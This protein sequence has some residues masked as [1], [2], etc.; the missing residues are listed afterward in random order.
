M[1]LTQQAM[2]RAA[3][4]ESGPFTACLDTTLDDPGRPFSPMCAA[5][6]SD[7]S[8]D[9]EI[10]RAQNRN[11]ALAQGFHGMA[12]QANGWSLFLRYQAQAERLYRRAVEEFDRLK[13]LR[14]ELRNEAILEVQPKENETSSAP[15]GEPISPPQPNPETVGQGIL[16]QADSQ[17]ASPACAKPHRRT[18]S[19]NQFARAI[20]RVAPKRHFRTQRT[21]PAL[22]RSSVFSL[23]SH[24][25]GLILLS[26]SRR[27]TSIRVP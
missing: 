3:R 21:L 4:L 25:K 14:P 6:A 18:K 10:T 20:R 2:L 5:L 19:H 15:P 8:L 22:S 1:A 9:I 12:R 27:N 23:L 11:F 17:P 16:P 24:R 13:A 26:M 7:L